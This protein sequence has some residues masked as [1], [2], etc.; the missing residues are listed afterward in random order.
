MP[1]SES[2][3]HF[4]KFNAL[5]A[6]ISESQSHFTKF[7]ALPANALVILCGRTCMQFRRLQF[8]EATI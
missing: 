4:A 7:N 6:N 8:I 3:S 1:L 2:Q 5:P